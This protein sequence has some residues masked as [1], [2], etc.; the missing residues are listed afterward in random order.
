VNHINKTIAFILIGCILAVAVFFVV[1]QNPWIRGAEESTRGHRQIKDIVGEEDSGETDVVLPQNED[2]EEEDKIAEELSLTTSAQAPSVA[3]V[4]R[5]VPAVEKSVTHISSYAYWI[6]PTPVLAPSR[7]NQEA[8]TAEP[9]ALPAFEPIETE[10]ADWTEVGLVA[11][12]GGTVQKVQGTN[13]IEAVEE[14]YAL[15]HRVFELDLNLTSDGRLVGI[16]DWDGKNAK[17]WAEFSSKPVGGI[18]TPTSIEMFLDFLDKHK[19]AYIITDTK[20]FDY[21]D[22]QVEEQF[23]VL[24]EATSARP[25]L[26]KRIVVQVYGQDMYYLVNK[27]YKYPNMIYTL[28]METDPEAE[29]VKFVD[30]EDIAVVVMPPERANQ[31]FLRK[32]YDTGAKV[33]IHTL[34]STEEVKEWLGKGASGVYTDDLLPKELLK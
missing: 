11:H 26:R 34:N 25:E 20:S 12:A 10:L 27:I 30:N 15:G 23:E 32:I 4:E 6:K 33:F 5:R 3:K 31:D 14:N 29:I 16:H 2:F 7:G 17:S 9:A 8:A 19:D 1:R 18:F 22:E 24:L 13:T 21:S 28:Y